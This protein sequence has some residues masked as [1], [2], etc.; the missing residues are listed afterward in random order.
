MFINVFE[1][2]LNSPEILSWELP[3]ERSVGNL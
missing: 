1:T 3:A 2:K